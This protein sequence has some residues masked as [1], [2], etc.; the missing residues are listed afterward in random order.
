MLAFANYGQ[1]NTYTIDPTEV[2]SNNVHAVEVPVGTNTVV[3]Q[4]GTPNPTQYYLIE[5]RASIG[6]DTELPAT[7]VLISY[8]D[9][10]AVVGKIHIMDGHPS[11]PGLQDAVWNIGQTFTDTKNSI[12]I[13]IA[14]KQGNSYQVIV[15][16]GGSQP[17]PPIQNQ[18]SYVDLAITG[19]N[20][21][22]SVVTLPN[23]NVTITAQISNLG[24]QDVTN[25]QVQVKLDG[26]IYSEHSSK[27]RSR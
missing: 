21:Q 6:F 12:S 15:N 17:P 1:T 22:P 19:V 10:N 8:V 9:N 13:T 26:T 24:T 3:S 11:V 4:S 16:R 2:P 25:V 27:R 20:T 18:T 7:G 5:V 14:S 23:T